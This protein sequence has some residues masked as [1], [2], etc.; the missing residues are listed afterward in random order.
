MLRVSRRGLLLGSVAAAAGLTTLRL[1]APA[2]AMASGAHHALLVAVTEYPRLSR[3]NWLTGPNNDARLVRN[4]LV[5]ESPA[6]FAPENVTVLA[7][8]FDG[9]AA[10]PT[11]SAIRTAM[12]DLAERVAP[13]DFVYMHFS[14]HGHQQPAR[15]PEQEID[16]LDEVF[17]PADCEIMT[18]ESRA[19]PNAYV[20]KDIRDDLEAI[21]G[22]GAFVW[23]VFDCCHSATLTRNVEQL[24]EDITPRQVDARELGVPDDVWQGVARSATG[25]PGRHMFSGREEP[26]DL[27]GQVAFFAS[28][29]IEPDRKSVV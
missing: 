12:S 28:Q 25:T 27:A 21:R 16:G 1:A 6:R 24:S 19:W 15:F 23:A 4:Y 5:N 14:G 22:K 8:N 3:N 10:S 29:T 9:A 26:Q 20:D 11:L 2:R 7:D 13:G 18:R 17:M